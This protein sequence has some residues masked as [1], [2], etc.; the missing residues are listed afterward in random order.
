SGTIE[1]LST[2][3]ISYRQ[4]ITGKFLASFTLVAIAL[5]PTFIYI[6]SI[7]WLAIADASI[8]Y[9][10]IAGSYT[11]L[12]LLAAAF[13]AVGIFCSSLTDNQIISFL[14]ALIICF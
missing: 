9:G 7:N 8:D 2:K 1:W 14:A 10:A 11:G 6:I 13:T 12:F 5:L 3:P 4:I